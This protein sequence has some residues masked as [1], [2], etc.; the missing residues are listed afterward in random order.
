[1]EAPGWVALPEEQSELVDAVA[2]RVSTERRPARL[3]RYR[4]QRRAGLGETVASV[5]RT[6][7]GDGCHRCNVD[8]KTSLTQSTPGETRTDT[9][10][11]LDCPLARAGAFVC[12]QQ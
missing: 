2:G 3:R 4:L 1:M 12:I 7:V 5:G 10:V 8:Y 6:C 9:D 11:V